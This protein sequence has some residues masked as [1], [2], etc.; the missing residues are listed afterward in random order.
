MDLS[1]ITTYAQAQNAIGYRLL[2][3][4]AMDLVD[5]SYRPRTVKDPISGFSVKLVKGDGFSVAIGVRKDRQTDNMLVEVKL[6]LINPSNEEAAIAGLNGLRVSLNR[7]GF[8]AKPIE[9][10]NGGFV[11]KFLVSEEDLL[12]AVTKGKS[13]LQSAS[14]ALATGIGEAITKAAAKEEPMAARV[15]KAGVSYAAYHKSVKLAAEELIEDAAIELGE[16]ATKEDVVEYAREKLQ[17]L[18]DNLEEA[19]EIPED[20]EA[21]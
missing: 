6:K 11:V 15:K 7:I 5:R 19:A 8:R 12:D 9:E 16:D 21:E 1:N 13:R 2:Q 14:K 3:P 18:M 17:D 10:K 4:L 20:L